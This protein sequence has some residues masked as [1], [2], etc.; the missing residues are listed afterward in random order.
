MAALL[1]SI[2]SKPP[3]PFILVAFRIFA[4]F[5][6]GL[7]RFLLALRDLTLS[8]PDPVRNAPAMV[9]DNGSSPSPQHIHNP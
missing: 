1:D 8:L 3:S 9:V 5:F 2:F 4:T 7:P 6:G